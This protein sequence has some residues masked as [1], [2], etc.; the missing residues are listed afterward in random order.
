[1]LKLFSIKEP[2]YDGETPVSYVQDKEGKLYFETR[3][4]EEDESL[5]TTMM[6]L[7]ELLEMLNDCE[8]PYAKLIDMVE[9][10][11]L[12]GVAHGDILKIKRLAEGKPAPKSG[13]YKKAHEAEMSEKVVDVIREFFQ[14]RDNITRALL[15]K[16]PQTV[17]WLAKYRS[18]NAFRAQHRHITS[19]SDLI[20]A[21]E[22]IQKLA[23]IPEDSTF[24]LIPLNLSKP[25][26]YGR[27]R[28]V[29]SINGQS[30]TGKTYFACQY[31]RIAEKINP[32]SKIFLFSSKKVESEPC[33]KDL[34]IIQIDTSRDKLAELCGFHV[35]KN[36][37]DY[38]SNNNESL[39]E[40][41][42]DKSYV[43][44]DDVESF[45]QDCRKMILHLQNSLLMTGRAKQ[46]NVICINHMLKQS[47]LTKTI[48]TEATYMVFFT[49]S[50]SA[51]KVADVISSNSGHTKKELAKYVDLPGRFF[52]I[53]MCQPGVIISEY[54]TIML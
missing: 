24:N 19:E 8:D 33:F 28:D 44:F 2:D 37:V 38:S 15:I 26:Q 35:N 9:Y 27:Q 41:F 40:L 14:K 48:Y 43:L 17:A 5:N 11:T 36:K 25:D 1:M 4:V 7:E 39:Y 10:L 34:P 47:H 6:S 50:M 16:T 18:P 22:F 23:R 32:G 49:K 21:H 31:L 13:R 51:A 54:A 30:G 45:N 42:P 46:I 12:N 52:C 20:P 3:I 29:I 53:S